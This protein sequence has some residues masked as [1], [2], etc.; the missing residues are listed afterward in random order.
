MRPAGGSRV[1]RGMRGAAGCNRF[2]DAAGRGGDAGGEAIRARLTLG[3]LA[4]IGRDVS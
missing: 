4:R 1:T 2:A 3:G